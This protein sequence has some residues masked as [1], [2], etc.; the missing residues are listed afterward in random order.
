MR[1][2]PYVQ[3][4][5]MPGFLIVTN[6]TEHTEVIFFA[7][8]TDLLYLQIVNVPTTRDMAV[9]MQ[10]TNKN[11]PCTYK[12]TNTYHMRNLC[13]LENMPSQQMQIFITAFLCAK[14]LYQLNIH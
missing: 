11:A 7:E 8:L 3:Y 6:D 1:I 14:Y 2:V 13:D 9:F 5:I 4:T 12:V 10:M